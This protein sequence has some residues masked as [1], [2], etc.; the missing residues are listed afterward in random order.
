MGLLELAQR[1]SITVGSGPLEL[2]D[3]DDSVVA[4]LRGLRGCTPVARTEIHHPVPRDRLRIH[5][6]DTVEQGTECP[7]S[8]RS[9]HAEFGA[10][11]TSA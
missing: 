1:W 9:V 4:Q 10:A 3:P 7:N 11:R 5:T 2:V 8:V 6:V